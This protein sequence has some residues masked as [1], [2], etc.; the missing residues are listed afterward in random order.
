MFGSV[1]D[2]G[3]CFAP[4]GSWILQAPAALARVPNGVQLPPCQ[5]R[6]SE[7]CPQCLPQLSNSL[8]AINGACAQAPACKFS[9]CSASFACHMCCAQ[10][11]LSETSLTLCTTISMYV[12]LYKH[13][14]NT[15]NHCH[16]CD[17]CLRDGLL[18]MHLLPPV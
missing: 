12:S 4:Q 13:S 5:G 18:L 16:L 7:P 11:P 15:I 8:P 3:S 2:C 14:T 17:A 6:H 9:L 10:H 1:N